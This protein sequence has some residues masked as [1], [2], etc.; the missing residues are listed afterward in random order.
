MP[1]SAC[2]GATSLAGS[3]A[4]P[5]ARAGSL[6]CVRG[7][8]PRCTAWGPLTKKCSMER[9]QV[10]PCSL[11]CGMTQPRPVPRERIS[12]VSSGSPMVADRPMRRGLTPAMRERRSMQ[13]RVCPP[14]SP[15][16]SECTSSITTKRRSLKSLATAECLCMSSASSDSG[17]I[18]R[19]P[20]GFLSMRALWEALTSPCQCHTGMPA[21][22]HRSF[23]R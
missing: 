7:W 20:E 17:V 22:A 11:T 9:R 8:G 6:I 19:M 13:H 14:R 4:G 15:R 12:P 2:S 3:S 21:S 5:A 18:C 16:R 10:R 1:G 23:R